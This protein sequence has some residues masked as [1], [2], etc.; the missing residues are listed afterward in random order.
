MEYLLRELEVGYTDQPT[1]QMLQRV[2]A[3]HYVLA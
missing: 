1:Y 3:E 2:F